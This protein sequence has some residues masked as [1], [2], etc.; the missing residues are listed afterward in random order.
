MKRILL[1][2]SLMYSVF[3]G[4]SSVDYTQ[5]VNYVDLDFDCNEN[6]SEQ[7]Y[8]DIYGPVTEPELCLD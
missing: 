5:T 3:G 8:Y 7:I 1:L 6:E 4:C 2:I